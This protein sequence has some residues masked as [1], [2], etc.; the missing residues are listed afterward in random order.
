MYKFSFVRLQVQQI[1]AI[2][3]QLDWVLLLFDRLIIF[4]VLKIKNPLLAVENYIV[5]GISMLNFSN[6]D[7]NIGQW[8]IYLLYLGLINKFR[9]LSTIVT[10][11]TQCLY[12]MVL[13]KRRFTEN[14]AKKLIITMTYQAFYFNVQRS[15]NR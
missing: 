8:A 3:Q 12:R 15:W 13:K 14:K 1:G 7:Q 4:T 11:I 9:N 6:E 2:R 5:L 10:P